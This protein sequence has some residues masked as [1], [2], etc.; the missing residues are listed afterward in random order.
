M[1]LAHT[2]AA[3]F[4]EFAKAGRSD[5][6]DIL[7]AYMY[8]KGHLSLAPQMLRVLEREGVGHDVPTVTVAREKD[9]LHYQKE[10]RQALF[11]VGSREDMPRIIVD[12]GAVGGF[13]VRTT[14][15]MVDASIRT[16][17]IKIYQNAIS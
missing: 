10:I 7:L 5:A 13:S 11:A 14:S 1:S 15:R 8:K 16:A 4:R 3:V 17:L 9:S 12:E 2:Y 6:P